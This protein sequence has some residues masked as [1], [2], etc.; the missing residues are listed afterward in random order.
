VLRVAPA[1]LCIR[2]RTPSSSTNIK[3]LK[4]NNDALKRYATRARYT[5]VFAR[6]LRVAPAILCIRARSPS[7]STNIK[8]IKKI[9]TR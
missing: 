4:K 7:P 3:K 8:K 6:A 9:I 2:A 5:R 1:V